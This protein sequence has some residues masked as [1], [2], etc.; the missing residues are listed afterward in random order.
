MPSYEIIENVVFHDL[1]L[2]IHGKRFCFALA[3][4]YAQASDV[5]GKFASTRTAPL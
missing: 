1:D 5:P 4:K 2:H 3:I